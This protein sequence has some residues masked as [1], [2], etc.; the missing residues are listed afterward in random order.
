MS[1]VFAHPA[2]YYVRYLCLVQED[3]GVHA[4]NKALRLAGVAE[5]EKDQHAAL[6]KDMSDPPTEFRPWAARHPGSVRWLKAKRVYTLV[7]QDDASR[8]MLDIVKSARLREL[9]ERMLI[10]GVSPVEI[11]Y[12]LR[13]LGWSADEGAVADF[14]HYFWN[15]ELMGAGDWAYYFRTDSRGRTRDV[16]DTYEASLYAGPQLALYRSGVRVEVDRKEAMHEIYRELVFTFREVKTLPTDAKKVE[17]LASL[18]RSVA[19]VDERIEAGD[20]ALQDVLK[21]FAKFRVLTDDAELPS[22]AQVAPTGSMSDTGRRKMI[23]AAGKEN[24]R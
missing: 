19:R 22:A 13:G 15:T 11:A 16:R 14:R 8:A 18:A 7:H 23:A 10:G 5:L 12:R 17:M 4:V 24:T 20:S 6:S 3:T 9:V 2:T 1:H 21:K